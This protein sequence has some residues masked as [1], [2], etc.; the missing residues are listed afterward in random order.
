MIQVDDMTI[1]KLSSLTSDQL[2]MITTLMNEFANANEKKHDVS[3]RIGIAKNIN[4]P[5]DFDDID[6]GTEDLF[7]LNA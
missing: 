3:K 1:Q 5:S 2:I 4:F 7:G 6:Y